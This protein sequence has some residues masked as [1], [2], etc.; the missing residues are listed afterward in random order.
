M[1]IA[2]ILFQMTVP[3]LVFLFLSFAI[4][5]CVKEWKH[6]TRHLDLCK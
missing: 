6:T 2:Q 3:P 4:V 5:A 1:Q